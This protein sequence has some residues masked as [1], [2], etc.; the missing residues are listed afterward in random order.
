MTDPRVGLGILVEN[1]REKV[2]I[3]RVDLRILVFP[4]IGPISPG[5]ILNFSGK[6]SGILTTREFPGNRAN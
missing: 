6:Q 5:S 3:P 2:T 4:G 1:P